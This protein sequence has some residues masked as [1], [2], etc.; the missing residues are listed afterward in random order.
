MNINML[1]NITIDTNIFE[2]I[3]CWLL[4]KRLSHQTY[5][6][7]VNLPF[8][9]LFVNIILVTLVIGHVPPIPCWHLTTCFF[10]SLDI[11]CFRS[12]FIFFSLSPI[13]FHIGVNLTQNAPVQVSDPPPARHHQSVETGSCR[14]ADTNA[15]PTS[16]TV[17]CP[18][19][20]FSTRHD[21]FF[22]NISHF[23]KSIRHASSLFIFFSYSLCALLLQVWPDFVG[24]LHFAWD[25]NWTWF[26]L[27]GSVCV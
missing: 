23:W 13:S 15:R 21:L 20:H 27:G 24:T 7:H 9:L 11:S 19:C 8:M 10:R 6:T 4:F 2:N 14:T 18:I 1:L 12:F 17:P 5:Q 16:P 25:M 3:E 22:T 26:A